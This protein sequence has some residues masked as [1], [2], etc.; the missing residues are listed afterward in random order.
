VIVKTI[1]DNI[2]IYYDRFLPGGVNEMNENYEDMCKLV[3]AIAKG[4]V[5]IS[6]QLARNHV[7]RFNHYMRNKKR[8]INPTR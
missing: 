4:K 8:Q 2:H 7:H 3:D 5:E 6:T 1:H